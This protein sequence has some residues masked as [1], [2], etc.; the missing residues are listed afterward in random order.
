MT[1]PNSKPR[2]RI[3]MVACNA[4]L[5]TS[6]TFMLTQA[7]YAVDYA[8]NGSVAV[9]MHCRNP[10]DAAIIEIVLPERNGLETLIRLTSQPS[11]PKLIAM[12]GENR[13]PAELYLTMAR[14]LG[15]QGALARP[16]QLG[17]LLDA[18]RRVLGEAVASFPE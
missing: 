1:D 9:L 7:G 15:A 18:V 3:L 12:S 8:A 2:R 16:S 5:Q 10:F 11:P 17:Q 4:G 6:L 13:I 14:H